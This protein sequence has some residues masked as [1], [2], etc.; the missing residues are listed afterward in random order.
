MQQLRYEVRVLEMC[1]LA[2]RNKTTTEEQMLL[3]SF[4]LSVDPR[5][6]LL[7][8]LKA[9]EHVRDQFYLLL[10]SSRRGLGMGNAVV[11]NLSNTARQAYNSISSRTSI[12]NNTHSSDDSASQG[13]HAGAVDGEDGHKPNYIAPTSYIPELVVSSCKLSFTGLIPNPL[14]ASSKANPAVSSSS[15]SSS[16]SSLET[17]PFLAPLC[18][19]VTAEFEIIN[20]GKHRASWSFVRPSRCSSYVLSVEP[21]S[22]VVRSCNH[23]DLSRAKVKVTLLLKTTMRLRVVLTLNVLGGLSFFL[24]IDVQGEPSQFGA[25]IDQ[26]EMAVDPANNLRVPKILL[27]LKSYLLDHKAY[28]QEGIFRLAGDEHEQMKIK[29]DLNSG[30][31]VSTNDINCIA[32]LLKIWFREMP[33][34]LLAC[35]SPEL[36]STCDC[37]EN[38]IQVVSKLSPANQILLEWLLDLLCVFA[39]HDSVNKMSVKNLA[40]V[41]SPNLFTAPL[42]VSALDG[43]LLSQ[44]AV[45]L[46]YHLLNH[47]MQDQAA[48]NTV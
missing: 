41:V 29:T 40:I 16:S 44:K 10:R 34:Q 26:L 13:G 33:E 3:N 38:T 9:H 24:P 45:G 27:T 25:A 5:T 37:Y 42:T 2:A 31:F 15:S 20:N 39:R 17:L 46:L 21:L 11:S 43:L 7:Y 8:Q 28:L 30:K 4:L 12:S 22:G 18:K 47:K 19:E 23:P 14:H 36:L 6:A 1:V 48:G 32:G 35:L